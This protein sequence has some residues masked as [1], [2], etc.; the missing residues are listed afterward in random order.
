MI[1]A[2]EL[3]IGN[4]YRPTDGSSG[5]AKV[6]ADDLKAWS[7][8]AVY[9]KYIPLTPEILEKCGF[10]YYKLRIP[11]STFLELDKDGEHFNIFLKQ[12]NEDGRTDSILLKYELKYLQQLQN[13][14]FAL[15]GEEL[16]IKSLL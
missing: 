12:I 13:L 3:R 15:T 14:Y 6:T 4:Y 16:E 11:G 1:K 2:N 8:G 5:P 10:E 7:I 9:G